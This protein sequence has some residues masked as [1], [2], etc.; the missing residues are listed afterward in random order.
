[1][2]GFVTVSFLN[3][4][5]KKECPTYYSGMMECILFKNIYFFLEFLLIKKCDFK[6]Y[7]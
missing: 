7:I 3:F 4:L 1:M 2:G 6:H 5:Y